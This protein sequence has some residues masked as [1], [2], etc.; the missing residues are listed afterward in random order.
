MQHFKQVVFFLFNLLI[1][2]PIWAQDASSVSS[3]FGTKHMVELTAGV[4]ASNG[5][6]A[7]SYQYLMGVGKGKQR[8][9]IGVG[10]RN[11][12]FFGGR[13]P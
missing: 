12:S 11:T 1:L 3:S 5:S 9:R 13:L 8:F 4:G 7:P 10:L 2:N 6:I